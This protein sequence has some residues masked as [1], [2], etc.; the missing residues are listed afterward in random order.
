[1]RGIEEC[2][3][4]RSSVVALVVVAV[5]FA[6][7]GRRGADESGL[8]SRYGFYAS[9]RRC[10]ATF[11]PT[12][13]T[14]ETVRDRPEF[15]AVALAIDAEAA[16]DRIQESL[17]GLSA[18]ETADGIKL[19]TTGGMLIAVVGDRPESDDGAQSE[20]VY[21][22]APSSEQATRKGRKAF[23]AVESHTV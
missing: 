5:A 17:K 7:G 20:L 1:V 12:M 13:T 6:S 8:D 16:R 23:A 21:R 14:L 4:T 19:R 2:S 3:S 15:D 11:D 10:D 9:R 18:T 22:T